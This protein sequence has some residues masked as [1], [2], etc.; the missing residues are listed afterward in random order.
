[1]NET[2]LY[3]IASLVEEGYTSG[4]Y[5][6][7]SITIEEDD[8]DEEIRL[9]YIAKLIREGYTNGYDPTWS[10]EIEVDEEDDE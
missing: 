10:I 1:M 4:Y 9:N 5:P 8:N 3:Y 7:W 2:K 6:T